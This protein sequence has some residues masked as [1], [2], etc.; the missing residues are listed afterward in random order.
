[1]KYKRGY[2]LLLLLLF[3]NMFAAKSQISIREIK[4]IYK[5]K[6]DGRIISEKEFQ[7]FRGTHIYHKKV[8]GVKGGRD[9]I[10]IT[11]PKI[12][13]EK[14][15]SAA[16]KSQIGKKAK[17]FNATD[18]YGNDVQFS[19]LKGKVIVLNFW[20]V[21]CPPCILEMPELNKLVEEYEQNKSIVFIGLALDSK[22]HLGKFLSHTDFDYQIIPNSKKIAKQFKVGAYPSHIIIDKKGIVRYASIGFENGSIDKLKSAIKK[23]M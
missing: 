3:Y 18:I 21:A 2:Y 9:T 19:D 17:A 16:F 23:A 6:V 4:A 14:L 22:N 12:N 5:S 10:Y 13:K 1:M 8:K 11:P 15:K 20:F 7:T